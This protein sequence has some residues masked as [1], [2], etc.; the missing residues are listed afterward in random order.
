VSRRGGTRT[1][2]VALGSSAAPLLPPCSCR[3]SQ[4]GVAPPC[5]D[6][7]RA[8]ACCCIHAAVGGEHAPR[9]DALWSGAALAAIPTRASHL[10]L[11]DM[12]PVLFVPTAQKA[13][14]SVVGSVVCVP[15]GAMV[16]GAAYGRDVSAG[17]RM[18]LPLHCL[19]IPP[20]R[21]PNQQTTYTLVRWQRRAHARRAT[22]GCWRCGALQ[23]G[24]AA[25]LGSTVYHTT[26]RHPLRRALLL[27]GE[28]PTG[29]GMFPDALDAGEAQSESRC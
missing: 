2:V 23:A 7:W 25:E 13:G 17:A 6:P 15:H 21:C 18:P 11:V 27:I 3:R 24:A 9:G 12:S 26:R 19:P 16:A 10:T 28:A 29:E 8:Y 20:T 4:P 5:S 14:A 1:S 22:R